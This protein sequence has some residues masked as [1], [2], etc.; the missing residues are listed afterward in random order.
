MEEVIN[1]VLCYFCKEIADQAV[2]MTCCGKIFCSKCV[3]ET[4]YC[5]ECERNS[6]IFQSKT[7]KKIIDTLPQL[8]RFCR[9]MYLM[10]DKKDHLKACPM[11]ETV[12]KLCSETVLE[13]ELVKHLGEKHEEFVKEIILSQGSSDCLLMPR[14]NAYGRLA[15]L[16]RNGKYYCEGPIGWGCGCCNGTCGPSAGCNCAACQKLDISLRSLPQGFYV[17]KAGAI[18]KSTGKGF[19]CGCGVLEKALLCDGYCGPDNG[20]RCK[21]CVAFQKCYRFLLEAL[22][23]I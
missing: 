16:G 21:S 15:K 23:K 12:C 2:E 11:A 18:C 6:E 20:Q 17:N 13:R 9:E 19:Y 10:R 8:C 22:N 5:P 4:K 14:K 3:P 7:L 1:L